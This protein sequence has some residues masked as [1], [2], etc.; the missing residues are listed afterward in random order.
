[1]ESFN[2]KETELEFKYDASDIS[3]EQF[4]KWAIDHGHRRYIETSSWDIYFSSADYEQN[5]LPFEFMR[6]RNGSTPELTIKR[7]NTETN[8]NNRIEIDL[9]LDAAHG[10]VEIENIVT[11]FCRQFGFVENFRVY[12]YCSIYFYEK[13]DIVYYI[14]YDTEMKEQA[15]FIEIEALKSYPFKTAEEALSCIKDVEQRMSAIGISPQK[16]MRKSMWER[17]KK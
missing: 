8:N 11:A 17:F 13:F 1:M 6:L 3:L 15:R 2:I 9:P 14:A 10:D 4:E 7:K 16:R 5:K 12:K